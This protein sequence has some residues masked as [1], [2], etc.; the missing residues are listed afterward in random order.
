MPGASIATR[1]TADR[2]WEVN[3]G[4]T[5]HAGSIGPPRGPLGSAA[6]RHV[7]RVAPQHTDEL[8]S[9]EPTINAPARVLVGPLE[10]RRTELPVQAGAAL[11]IDGSRPRLQVVHAVRVA[12]PGRPVRISSSASCTE[13]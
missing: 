9:R 12:A 4:R 10:E 3:D 1:F 6:L 5:G 7:A 13:A 8:L 11:L 2:A